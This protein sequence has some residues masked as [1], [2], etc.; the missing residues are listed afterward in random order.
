MKKPFVR[1]PYNYNRNEATDACAI[2]C[3]EPGRTK[4]AFKD[5]CDINT[6]VKRFGLTG[7]LP[8]NRRAPTY[9]DYSNIGNFH[10]AMNA[11]LEANETFSK[12]PARIRSQFD[13]DPEKFVA[14]S[15]QSTNRAQLK[16]WGLLVPEEPKQGASEPPSATPAAAPTPNQPE[17][18]KEAQNG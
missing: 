15:V 13:N 3:T 5:E 10:D 17:P 2:N 6:I 1:S 16:E 4:Q 14:F 11:V 7:E 12:L 9:G 18:R 8:V